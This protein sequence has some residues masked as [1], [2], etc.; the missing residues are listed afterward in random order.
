MVCDSV[1]LR[2]Q[3][4]GGARFFQAGGGGCRVKSPVIAS[5]SPHSVKR[6]P[7]RAGPGDDI[8]R[9][10]SHSFFSFLE[11]AGL[12]VWLQSKP[13]LLPLLLSSFSASSCSR[14]TPVSPQAAPLLLPV[15]GV[16]TSTSTYIYSIL[17]HLASRRS[18]R[19]CA[20]KYLRP[21][22]VGSI[23]RHSPASIISFL[24]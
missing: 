21:A 3:S 1:I 14:P 2:F 17:T 22:G 19:V 8:C 24:K 15:P 18:R 20:G 10:G 9:P 11:S 12:P 16:C 13:R 5:H 23:V 6:R 4:H 7:G